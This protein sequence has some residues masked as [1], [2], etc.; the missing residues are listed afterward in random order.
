MKII[1]LTNT[2]L[3]RIVIICIKIRIALQFK[4]KLTKAYQPSAFGERAQSG[5]GRECQDRFKDINSCLPDL[6]LSCLDIGCNEGYFVFRM[7]ERGGFCHGIDKGR[8]EI[9]VADGLAKVNNINNISFSNAE[10]DIDYIAGLP[11]YDVVIF[12]SVFHHIARHNGLQYA[13]E[14]MLALSHINSKYLIFETGQPNELNTTWAEDLEFMRP[15]IEA[16]ISEMLKRSGYKKI[17]VIGK[18]HGVYSD[19]DRLLFLAEK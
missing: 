7:S 6:P 17:S 15:N 9:M 19:V 13:E 16:W 4:L 5:A 2:I 8:N 10:I 1:D 14:F 18:N 3:Y 11:H 12:M